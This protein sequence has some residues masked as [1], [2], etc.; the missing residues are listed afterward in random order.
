MI[1]LMVFFTQ[2]VALYTLIFEDRPSLVGHSYPQHDLLYSESH[3]DGVT[4]FILQAF[5][6]QIYEFE[7][8]Y[9]TSEASRSTFN[10]LGYVAD[11]SFYHHTQCKGSRALCFLN[12][13]KG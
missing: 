12:V 4:R 3:K 13:Y 6:I 10:S 2:L 9:S 7:L 11:R 1:G 5:Y 8:D